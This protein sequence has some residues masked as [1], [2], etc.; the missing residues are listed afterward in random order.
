[1]KHYL[2]TWPEFFKQI[3][4][5][6]K[7]FEIRKNDRDFEKYDMLR[8][9]EWDPTIGVYTGQAVTVKVTYIMDLSLFGLPDHVAMAISPAFDIN[10][11]QP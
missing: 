4:C 8:L 3:V 10:L 11:N 2:K 1:M 6:N 5:G 9:R 7:T